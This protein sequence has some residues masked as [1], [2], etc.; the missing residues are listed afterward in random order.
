MNYLK[1]LLVRDEEDNEEEGQ[2]NNTEATAEQVEQ[3]SADELRRRRMARF[4][5]P[6][7]AAAA[8]PVSSETPPATVTSVTPG[9]KEDSPPKRVAI[10]DNKPV[11]RQV[12]A[13][14]EKKRTQSE[15]HPPKPA[16]V[17]NTNNALV[18]LLRISLSNRGVLVPGTLYLSQIA[19]ECGTNFLNA[20]NLDAALCSRMYMDPNDFEPRPTESP[21]VY[22]IGCFLRLPAVLRQYESERVVLEQAK[23]LLVNFA[24]TYLL[25]P[26]LFP[27]SCLAKSS[28]TGPCEPAHEAL[29]LLKRQDTSSN[30]VHFLITILPE[31]VSQRCGKDIVSVWL[32][33]LSQ[34][35]RQ[36]R[37]ETLEF[38]LSQLCCARS[39]KLGWARFIG[40]ILKQEREAF[41]PSQ[42]AR[43]GLSM[44]TFGAKFEHDSVL[45]PFFASIVIGFEGDEP[46]RQSVMDAK[47]T[48]LSN[49]LKTLS[50]AVLE[51]CKT[52][53][54][55]RTE[56]LS[57]MEYVLE[58]NEERSKDRPQPS[59]CSSD[60]MIFSIT[61][62]LLELCAPFLSAEKSTTTLPLLQSE[63]AGYIAHSKAFPPAETKLCRDAPVASE[64]KNEVN[65]VK[66]QTRVF[67]LALR[68]V[69]LGP[70]VV[71]RRLK[72][73]QRNFHHFRDQ[74]GENDPQI[75]LMAKQITTLV[76]TSFEPTLVHTLLKFES[77]VCR[78]MGS[79]LLDDDGAAWKQ[80]PEFIVSDIPEIFIQVGQVDP[81]CLELCDTLTFVSDFF[82]QAIQFDGIVAHVRAPMG[83]ALFWAFLPEDAKQFDKQQQQQRSRF[84]ASSRQICLESPLAQT[85]LV[86]ALMKLYGDVQV[87]GFYQVSAHRQLITKIL[88]YLWKI[89]SHRRAFQTFAETSQETE[90]DS[91]FI[92]LANGILNQTNSNV[93]E[94]LSKLRE[95]RKIQLEQKTAAWTERTKEDRDQQLTLLESHEKEVTSCLMMAND[96]TDMLAYLSSDAAFVRAFTVPSLRSRLVDM[97]GCILGNLGSKK[98]AEFK[99]DNPEKY[100][101]F[102]KKM[103]MEI[104][105]TLLNCCNKAEPAERQLFVDSVAKSAYF[106]RDTFYNADTL[107]RKHGI[108]SDLKEMDKFRD[109]VDECELAR[110]RM[111]Q[112]DED[113]GEIPDEFLDPLMQ[114]LMVDPV[115]LPGSKMTVD[116]ETIAHHLLENA[117]D[118]FDRSPLDISQI[119]PDED[120]KARIAAWRAEKK[121]G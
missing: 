40:E 22:I 85:S 51:M 37:D 110:M 25:E 41:K 20:D 9:Q 53:E 84:G 2:T 120:I 109:F 65:K 24:V 33:K 15:L 86:P 119:V 4:Q 46:I 54:F 61:Y 32:N 39:G 78:W 111:E 50:Q 81:P 71:Y 90:T 89:S 72:L 17:N 104:F 60:S 115:I 27:S 102:P 38:V 49:R 62:V 118:P 19:E 117:N 63:T 103:L 12:E 74:L 107:V 1:G 44:Q 48:V 57:W 91:A 112:E 88:A 42:P 105:T 93:T 95:I 64:E 116:R 68:A 43:S 52:D 76:A 66:F 83:D 94:S 75:R 18:Q 34:D 21:L 3:L 97:L 23:Q 73:L 79:A 70:V 77:L 121:E 5:T 92:K 67:A 28:S 87:T 96:A 30:F 16:P 11:V 29:D 58:L 59:K 31:V 26:T 80:L 114:T 100:N 98:N 99:I 113:L 108:M 14:E 56:I 106:N 69:N 13:V 82:V 101:F 10:D 35:Q 47:R 36:F 7:A 8:A 55:T 45:S 6:T